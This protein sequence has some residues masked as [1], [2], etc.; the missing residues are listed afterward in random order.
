[1][2][3]GHVEYIQWA[4]VQGL[5]VRGAAGAHWET[6]YGGSGGKTWALHGPQGKSV[7]QGNGRTR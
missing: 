4:A 7:V 1:M 2:A 6:G 3:V 5:L